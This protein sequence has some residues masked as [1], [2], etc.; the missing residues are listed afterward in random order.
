[1]NNDH[2]AILSKGIEYWNNWRK[3]NPSVVPDL[4]HAHLYRGWF[5]N[6][7]FDNCNLESA[8][9]G[10]STSGGATFQNANLNHTHF[11][12]ATLAHANFEGA[13]FEDT[14]FALAN[15]QGAN[16]RKSNLSNL[17]M[18]Q[19]NLSEAN[20]S[21]CTIENTNLKFANLYKTNVDNT[22]FREVDLQGA[23]LVDTSVNNTSFIDCKIRGVSVWNLHGKIRKTANLIISSDEEP[24]ITT[25]N[26]EIAQFINLMLNNQN[27][28]NVIK[29]IG[30]K[31]VLILGRFSIE[32]KEILDS[33]RNALKQ[34]NFVPMIF[35]FDRPTNKDFT[36]TIKIL[37]GISKFVIADITNP[38]SSPLELQATIPD[39]QIPFIPIIQQGEK[40]FSMFSDL[41]NKYDWVSAPLQYDNPKDLLKALD[42]GIIAEANRIFNEIQSKK[43]EEIGFRNSTDYFES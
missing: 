42:K 38:S 14:S 26:L 28:S 40:P 11:M 32:R 43:G 22:T 19:S 33:L 17:W 18:A 27:L 3:E 10:D 24:L 15:L 25:D 6:G 30:S 13:L 12:G 7:N 1:M 4:S 36:E 16:L 9:F 41:Y 2:L 29:T 23:Q 20:L 39:Y 8:V 37:A 21:G 35:D 31:G 34:R 5:V